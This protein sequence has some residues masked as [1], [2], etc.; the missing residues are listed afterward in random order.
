MATTTLIRR[1]HD[2]LRAQFLQRQSARMNKHLARAFGVHPSVTSR[3]QESGGPFRAVT[4]DARAVMERL[5]ADGCTP[6]ALAVEI[7]AIAAEIDLGRRD[8]DE[9]IEMANDLKAEE[10]RLQ[11][12]E[13]AA[14]ERRYLPETREAF[15]RA[16]LAEARVQIQLAAV[17]YV[18]EERDADWIRHA[19]HLGRV[20]QSA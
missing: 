9:L 6:W 4:R 17:D 19:I 3:W 16:H 20:R 7:L 14:S 5:A 10:H 8:T 2:D 15:R 12:E 11:A 18:L 1:K 13:D